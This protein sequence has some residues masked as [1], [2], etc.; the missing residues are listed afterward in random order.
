MSS[1]IDP[2][3]REDLKTEWVPDALG[4]AS[5]RPTPPTMPAERLRVATSGG[6]RE[7][8]T[9][10]VEVR[11][12]ASYL[13][14]QPLASAEHL[15]D[16]R[17]HGYRDGITSY[18]DEFARFLSARQHLTR[19]G[20]WIAHVDVRNLF[21]SLDEERAV[22]PEELKELL[23][24]CRHSFGTP[25]L[26]GHRWSRRV[27]NL[28]LKPVDEALTGLDWIR[29]QDDYWI[30]IEE[31]EALDGLSELIERNL[32]EFGLEV[33]R[34]KLAASPSAEVGAHGRWAKSR[35]SSSPGLLDI[36]QGN[37]VARIKYTLRR[38]TEASDPQAVGEAARLV[39]DFPV[40]APRVAAYLDAV[41]S[42]AETDLALIAILEHPEDWVASRA[43]AVVA[44]H[45][46]LGVRI[47]TGLIQ[48][49]A[50]NANASLRALAARVQRD[51][52]EKPVSSSRRID[53]A[54]AQADHVINEMRPRVETTL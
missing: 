28:A 8:V 31:P 21:A 24:M 37:D 43:M 14:E 19:E 54:L 12:W 25:L 53:N 13:C 44:R 1:D 38:L 29:W 40:L 35:E 47:S 39:Y 41:V 3:L 49:F 51:K 46:R 34:N 9:V 2:A 45:P 6:Y 33:N 4:G 11:A 48:R 23:R 18:R 20:G 52:G 27:A 10:G 36:L 15:L 50:S 5:V 22:L 16:R 30:S 32:A 17:V 7:V 26:T 42:C